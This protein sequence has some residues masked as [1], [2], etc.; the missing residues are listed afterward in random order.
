MKSPKAHVPSYPFTAIHGQE[1][2]KQALILCLIDPTIGGVLAVGDRGA[3]KTTLIRS[4]AQ[5]MTTS[6]TPFPFVNLPIGATEDRLLGHVN[7]E[8]LINQKQEQIQPGLLAE[9]HQGVLY[10]D[11]VNLL[12]DYLMDILLDASAS[13]SYFLEREGLSQR[14]DSRFILIGSMNPEEGALRPQL[15]DRFGLSVEVK[16]PWQPEARMKI[17][18]DR[19]RFD[20]GPEAFCQSHESG[21][22]ALRTQIGEARERLGQVTISKK[23]LEQ[24]VTL[25]LENQVEGM[26]ADILLIKAAAALAAFQNRKEVA[27]AD[28][29]EVAPLVLD[30]RRNQRDQQ[31]PPPPAPEHQPSQEQHPNNKPSGV[32]NVETLAPHTTLTLSNGH[33]EI[34]NGSDSELPAGVTS[35]MDHRS[36]IEKVDVRKTVTQY[37]A[38]DKVELKHKYAA[39]Q[40]NPALVFLIDSSGSMLKDRAIAYA[41]GLV[42]KT[43]EKQQKT[44]FGLVAIHHS[45][46]QV[47]LPFSRDQQAVEAVL[48]ELPIG[49]KTNLI[50]GLGQLGQLVTGQR[51]K[52]TQVVLITDGRFNA[53]AT[54]NVF[55]ETIRACQQA[56]TG[57]ASVTVVD[58][59]QGA[60]RLGLAKAFAER[61]KAD[62]QPLETIYHA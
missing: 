51:K 10:V 11:E 31:N 19:M 58:S 2:F 5:L 33:E 60:V 22:R 45:K 57:Y 15:R 23:N 17:I 61:V 59:E 39:V 16:A 6:A 26:R 37:V 9:A 47:L 40:S 56:L 34:R 30:H 25:A 52:A 27:E 36:V 20:K 54:D 1:S 46:A 7:V 12:N 38:T 28:I 3:G 18:E 24:S 43:S 14:F 29:R 32:P 44:E 62:Y 55:E 21:E 8:Q 13:G 48:N 49:G 35:R 42:R 50:A 4:L 53:G 41:K